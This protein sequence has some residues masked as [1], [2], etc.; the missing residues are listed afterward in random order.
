M[1]RIT[2]VDIDIYNSSY[3]V[4]SSQHV[5]AQ[6]GQQ[7]TAIRLYHAA[8]DDLAVEYQGQLWTRSGDGVILLFPKL[9]KAL[10]ASIALLDR[11]KEINRAVRSEQ[12]GLAVFMR[13]GIH[14]GD[15]SLQAMAEAERGV[16]ESRDLN[17]VGKLQKNCPI[18]RIAISEEVYRSLGI[19]QPLFRPSLIHSGGGPAFVLA[20]RFITPQEEEL[21]R[22]LAEEQKRSMPP[23]PFLSWQW[24]R[25]NMDQGLRT[26]AKY[27]EEPVLIVLGES[28]DRDTMSAA[29]T[30]DAVGLLEAMAAARSNTHVKV[31]IDR[32][33]DT[34][35]LVADRHIIVVGS[36]VVNAYAFT[37]NNIMHP[38]RFLRNDGKILYQIL[39]T[40]DS[41]TT[42]F[43]TNA[44]DERDAGFVLVSKS[45][46]SPTK[47]AIW[48][49][50]THDTATQAAALL[51]KDLVID[52][53]SC[54]HRIGIDQSPHPV[55]CVVVPVAD[56]DASRLHPQEYSRRWRIRGY[57]AVWAVDSSGHQLRVERR[58]RST[59]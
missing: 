14:L 30:S 22:G 37:I 50:G 39:A 23:V 35:D 2:L 46:F 10:E 32:W 25:P 45:P 24:V 5:D 58:R 54:L 7:E 59:G 13:I 8:L 28:S 42:S 57:E 33:S 36:G 47:A 19:Q 49:A 48:V 27:L 26:I 12:A 31:A 29:A 21:F 38:L 51:F 11:L 20:E 43:G 55:G 56:L 3:L 1:D 4:A 52:A 34:A 17:I 15:P 41:G 6:P 53:G 9:G 40:S 16:A 18:G 44:E